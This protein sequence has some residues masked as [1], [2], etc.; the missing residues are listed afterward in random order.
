MK[1]NTIYIKS[2]LLLSITSVLFGCGMLPGSKTAQNRD[3]FMTRQQLITELVKLD[4]VERS[5]K[6]NRR[7]SSYDLASSLYWLPGLS[8]TKINLNDALSLIAQRRDYLN[9]IFKIKFTDHSSVNLANNQVDNSYNTQYWDSGVDNNSNEM[10]SNEADYI[11][12]NYKSD[13]FNYGSQN[14]YQGQY[15]DE[16]IAEYVDSYQEP[17]M[18]EP[19]RERRIPNQEQL[20]FD[21]QDYSS[22]QPIRRYDNR[23]EQRHQLARRNARN[24]IR[25]S[26]NIK[27]TRDLYYNEPM[28]ARPRDNWEEERYEG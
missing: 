28:A 2:V 10:A 19:R 23:G 24:S 22:R 20:A 5:V 16:Y 18:R 11:A 27:D 14:D 15:A 4:R 21:N 13:D 25:D 7:Q 1:I 9:N 17:Q 12:D 8:N 3:D 26:R 6:F